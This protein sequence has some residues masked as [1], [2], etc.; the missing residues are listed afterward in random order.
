MNGT[1]RRTGNHIEFLGEV[2]EKMAMCLLDAI[3]KALNEGVD[4]IIVSICSG[5][6]DGWIAF[7]L[8]ARIWKMMRA[9]ARQDGKAVP[10]WTCAVGEVSSAGIV[11][12]MAGDHRC[13]SQS[14]ELKFHE[15]V[16][17]MGPKGQNVP[18]QAI[19]DSLAAISKQEHCLCADV[20]VRILMRGLLGT[21][22][23]RKRLWN[24]YTRELAAISRQII[25]GVHC[26]EKSPAVIK[27]L[28][29]MT[30]DA[31]RRGYIYAGIIAR[32]SGLAVKDVNALMRQ[33]ERIDG[34]Q[35]CALGLAH[36]CI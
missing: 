1:V 17:S 21:S 16:V 27:L 8:Y 22:R 28:K 14:A 34:A 35:A 5:G 6:G 30:D 13:M 12:F 10:L 3:C 26:C 9:N 31:E 11:L 20:N 24:P 4:K 25:K 2:N 19:K 32:R 29:G 36:E 7:Q 18:A 15:G 33:S 23:R